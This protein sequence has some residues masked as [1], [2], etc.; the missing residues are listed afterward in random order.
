[1][2]EIKRLGVGDGAEVRRAEHLFDDLRAAAI[3]GFLV[4]STD[5]LLIAYLDGEPAGA[6]IAHELSRLD[7]P[8]NMMLYSIDTGE[9]F[10]RRGVAR[11]LIEAV[12]P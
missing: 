4:S 10:R 9:A 7:G 12:K 1:V 6:L 3:R 8:P 5:H 2:I 11:A